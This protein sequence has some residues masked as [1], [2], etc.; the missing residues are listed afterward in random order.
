LSQKQRGQRGVWF[1]DGFDTC[2]VR[3]ALPINSDALEMVDSEQVCAVSAEQ[4][5][6][7]NPEVGSWVKGRKRSPSQ[8]LVESSGD[9]RKK[10]RNCNDN[11]Y[12]KL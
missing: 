10:N 2:L 1:E 4:W 8:N 12:N 6:K 11:Y 5:Q 9:G 7:I 3:A